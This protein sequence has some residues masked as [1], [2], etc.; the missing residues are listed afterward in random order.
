[1]RV[2]VALGGNALLRRGRAADRGEPARERARRVQGARAGRARARARD[3]ARQRPAGRPARAAGLGL[4]GGRP[5][6]ARPA[7]RADRGDDRLPDPA[8]ARQRAAVREAPRV[9][10]DADRGRRGR[11]G[12]RRSDEADRADLRRGRTPERLAAEKGWMFKPDG[13]SFRRVV[14]SPLPKRIFGLEP[15]EWLLEQG[16]VVI[17]AGGGGIPVMYTDEP[18]PAGPAARRRRGRDRQGP[19]ERAARRATCDADALVI[20]TDVDAVYAGWGT[21]EQRAIRRATPG[22]ARR[23]PSS[24]PARWGRRSGPRA[25]SSR[26]RAGSR[27]SARSRTRRRCCAARPA[28]S[29]PATRTDWNSK[30]RRAHDRDAASRKRQPRVETRRL[31]RPDGEERARE[32]GVDPAVGLDTAEVEQRRGAVRPEQAR[33]GAEGAGLARVPAPVPRP[34]AARPARRRDRQHRRAAGVRRPVS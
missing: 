31:A 26:R 9:A 30:P 2:V 1:M 29:S 20:V 33:G 25:R 28:R 6:P 34:D 22:G 24:R 5:V 27:R 12:V 17:C 21:P 10:A 18:V 23:A 16:C 14:P 7:R 8:G 19:R 13:D 32:L 15:L 4:H 3:L 11:S